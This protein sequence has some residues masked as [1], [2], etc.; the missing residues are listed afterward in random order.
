MLFTDVSAGL[1]VAA[2]TK[3]D[4][5]WLRDPANPRGEPVPMD[6]LRLSQWWSGEALLVRKGRGVAQAEAPFGFASVARLVFGEREILRHVVLAS[7]V[8]SVLAIVPALLTSIVL[9]R[10]LVYQSWSTLT[11]VGVMVGITVLFE[12]LLTHAR[13]E[14]L[15]V[16]STRID[17]Q[18]NLAVFER[19]LDVAARSFR[20]ASHGRDQPPHRP[21]LPDSRVS[22]Q[23]VDEYRPR[24][25]HAAGVAAGGVLASTHPCRDGAGSAPAS[26]P[27]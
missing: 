19:L 14:A 4:L 7:L 23:K 25:H 15:Q 13:G 5:A 9:D 24:R 10:V 8:L 1:I 20:A 3:R 21:D 22:D 26:S 27:S 18:L 12:A 2:D 11:L 17:A 16:L 6:A